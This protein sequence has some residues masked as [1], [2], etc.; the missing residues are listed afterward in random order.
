MVFLL[1]A[2]I[3][4]S[5]TAFAGAARTAPTVTPAAAATSPTPVP[6]PILMLSPYTGTP[7]ST[8]RAMGTRFG[9]SSK[10]TVTMAGTS[11]STPF[12]A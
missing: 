4:A 6:Y 7:G 2:L 1:P 10:G 3:V 8:L 9:A 5:G 12:Q 11:L